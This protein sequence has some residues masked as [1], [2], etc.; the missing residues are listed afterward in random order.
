MTDR[1]IIYSALATGAGIGIILEVIRFAV[2][3]GAAA[4][5]AVAVAVLGIMWLVR[6]P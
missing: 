6:S 3:P 4:G 2:G 1:Q 5:F